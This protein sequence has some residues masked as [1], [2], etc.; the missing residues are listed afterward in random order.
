LYSGPQASSN[1]NTFYGYVI[2]IYYNG[3]LQDSR[4]VPVKL[5]RDFPPPLFL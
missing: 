5:V 2:G 4:A 1:P 3:E